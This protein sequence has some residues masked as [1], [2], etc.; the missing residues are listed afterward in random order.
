MLSVRGISSSGRALPWHGRGEQFKSAMLHQI[1]TKVE[2]VAREGGFFH[3]GSDLWCIFT[4]KL[5]LILSKMRKL[6]P[7]ACGRETPGRPTRKTLCL[8][9]LFP[10]PNS[11]LKLKR[12]FSDGS[13]KQYLGFIQ[14]KKTYAE[15]SHF[16]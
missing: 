3:F 4:T 14:W 7:D 2:I 11:F 13:T 16:L 15:A 10:P 12:V 6:S 9:F 1:G 8:F 5:E